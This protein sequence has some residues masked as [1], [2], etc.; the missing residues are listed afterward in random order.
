MKQLRCPMNGMRNVSEFTYGGEFRVEPAVGDERAWAE[1]VFFDEN[2]AGTVIEW[3]CH[4]ASACWFLAER[5]TVSDE[6]IRTFLFSELN[7]QGGD[8]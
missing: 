2:A 4:T 5:N 1:Y 7:E 3:W 6:V 8:A